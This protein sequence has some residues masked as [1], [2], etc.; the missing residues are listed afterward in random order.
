[1]ETSAKFHPSVYDLEL[2]PLD[3]EKA[4]ELFCK[5]AFRVEFGG[6]CPPSLNDLSRKIVKKCGGLPLAIVAIAGLL[7]TKDRTVYEWDKLHSSLSS[8]LES[9]PHLT[10]I[11]RILLL[12]YYDLP[13][14]LKCCFLYFGMYP[15]DYS[16]KLSRLLRQWIAEGFIKSKKDKTLEGVAHQYLSEL[17][18]RSLVQIS[19]VHFLRGTCK[20]C[21]VHDLL[22]ESKKEA[23]HQRPAVPFRSGKWSR[24][25]SLYTDQTTAN[26]S[27]LDR[28]SECNAPTN[29]RCRIWE[30]LGVVAL[31]RFPPLTQTKIEW[32]VG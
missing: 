5:R 8:E 23:P 26:V 31:V 7:S 20:A 12:S 21:R 11:K 28:R 13:Y 18:H 29:V 17:I 4:Y 16:I 25:A 14:Y 2:K 3:P 24:T 10:S 15:E 27:P 32:S 9:N 6:R 1:M 19:D 30:R 22:H